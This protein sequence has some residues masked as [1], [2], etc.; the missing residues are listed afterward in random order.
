MRLFEFFLIL[1]GTVYLLDSI[2]IKTARKSMMYAYLGFA[3][4]ITV[5]HL[6]LEKGRWPMIPGYLMILFLVIR[7]IIIIIK[8]SQK[9]KRSRILS[10]IAITVSAVIYA[11]F[12]LVS[13]FL[14]PVFSFPEPKSD[15]IIGSIARCLTDTS[16]VDSPFSEKNRK[17]MIQ[18]W[19]P[20]KKEQGLKRM[21]YYPYP[22]MTEAFAEM[23]G[24]PGFFFS[25][26]KLVKTNS[27]IDAEPSNKEKSY[28]VIILSHG[29]RDTRFDYTF[30]TEELVRHGF[31]VIG[32]DH[33][34]YTSSTV[35]PD[36]VMTKVDVSWEAI[37]K[38]IAAQTA[39]NDI[40]VKDAEFVI[41][42]IESMNKNDSVL[43]G[44]FDINRLGYI[45][46]SFGGAT[47]LRTS[48]ADKRIK[49]AIDLDGYIPGYKNEPLKIPVMIM[50]HDPA[51]DNTI[52]GTKDYIDMQNSRDSMRQTYEHAM[53]SAFILQIKKTVH[54][55]Y[56]DVAMLMR[57][58]QLNL[59]SPKRC[60]R[61][62]DDY[63]LSF[64][65]RYLNNKDDGLLN[66]A[67]S[68]YPE[69]E[70]TYNSK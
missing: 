22:G 29:Y 42:Q 54:L 52:P 60:Y 68:M 3:S 47:A 32:I 27:Y 69:V 55:S 16:R 66:G 46:H 17:L 56:S 7:S 1:A 40:W 18:I 63:A 25:S 5:L 30:L 41:N 49:A 33:T 2:L 15:T 61:V 26:M 8:P 23:A 62:I 19:Y 37:T 43:K 48:L 14:I 11:L 20:A 24:Y 67:S 28:P 59:T 39:Q 50:E 35:F 57:A 58:F 38:D 10:K 36:G 6:I 65:N 34:H 31:I 45:G 12:A 9:K 70:L 13:P 4:V 21:D 51:T 64:F 44:K 53:N